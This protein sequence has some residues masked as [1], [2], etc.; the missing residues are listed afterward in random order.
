MNINAAASINVKN[1]AA[2]DTRVATTASSPKA[3]VPTTNPKA[4]P[5]RT[6]L[7]KDIV[8]ANQAANPHLPGTG[9]TTSGQTEQYGTSGYTSPSLNRPD[10]F[11][12]LTDPES[13]NPFDVLN[14]RTGW[15]FNPDRDLNL[16]PGEAAS[17]PSQEKKLLD[18]A[19]KVIDQ[20]QKEIDRLNA[21][22]KELQ[23][24][25]DWLNKVV[26]DLVNEIKRLRSDPKKNPNPDPVDNS[27]GGPNDPLINNLGSDRRI[28]QP[29]VDPS[30]EQEFGPSGV[31]KGRDQA[32]DPNPETD[33]NTGAAMKLIRSTSDAVTDPIPALNAALRTGTMI[34]G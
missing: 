8:Q 23:E 18:S 13:Q 7:L 24:K 20:Q 4:N 29:F 25:N 16:P 32:T 11:P 30:G 9:T 6:A 31:M 26:S 19:L 15:G 21:Q 12:G 33:P 22:N 2:V 5:I 14:Q 1:L 27:G 17:K 10:R 28:R 3:E 34:R